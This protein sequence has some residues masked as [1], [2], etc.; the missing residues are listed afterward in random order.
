MKAIINTKKLIFFA[1]AV[2]FIYIFTNL[3]NFNF[4]KADIFSI[5]ENSTE[6]SS[7]TIFYIPNSY[8]SKAG[9]TGEIVLKTHTEIDSI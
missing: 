5:G 9:Q 2:G 7:D 3:S 6:L 1:C 8:K 4:L